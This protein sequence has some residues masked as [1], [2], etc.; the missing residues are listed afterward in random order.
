MNEWKDNWSTVQMLQFVNDLFISN[1]LNV[2][3]SL[4]FMKWLTVA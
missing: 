2:M 3:F 1:M 4:M